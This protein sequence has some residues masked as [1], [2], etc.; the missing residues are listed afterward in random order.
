MQKLPPGK[1]KSSRHHFPR[2]AQAQ[3]RAISAQRFVF[4]VQRRP[5]RRI[6]RV[7]PVEVASVTITTDEVIHNPP[8]AIPSR[9]FYN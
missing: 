6:F 5:E 2:G 4:G 3:L 8:F 7:G 1:P 9:A